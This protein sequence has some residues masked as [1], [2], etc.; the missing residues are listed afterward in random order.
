MKSTTQ[1]MQVFGY[2]VYAS[3]LET[4]FNSTTTDWI[5]QVLP[6]Y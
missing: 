4:Y 2:I 3:W 6:L 5:L 1:S